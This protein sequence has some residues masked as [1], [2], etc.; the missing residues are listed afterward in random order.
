MNKYIEFTRENGFYMKCEDKY[1]LIFYFLGD[2]T[3]SRSIQKF[4]D[5]LEIIKS[6]EKTFEEVYADYATILIGH[7]QGEFECDAEQAYFISRYEDI[8]SVTIP[9]QDCID[10]LIEWRDFRIALKN[11]ANGNG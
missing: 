9:L 10:L 11:E 2:Y 8:P 3:S 6:G 7:D 4:I 5:E 1:I